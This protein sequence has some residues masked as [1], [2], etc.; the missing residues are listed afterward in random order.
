ME[1]TKAGLI[2][3]LKNRLSSAR[4]LMVDIRPVNRNEKTIR[5]PTI[6]GKPNSLILLNKIPCLI[7]IK[8]MSLMKW[9]IFL[10]TRMPT[11]R[12]IPKPIR[13]RSS[14]WA[15]NSLA[16]WKKIGAIFEINSGEKGYMLLTAF[17]GSP[18]NLLKRNEKKISRKNEEKIE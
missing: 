10:K 7:L 6:T 2:R 16:F 13:P 8:N 14:T 12:N 18:I 9:I 15:V 17:P 3:F 5:M 4:V 11:N 1:W